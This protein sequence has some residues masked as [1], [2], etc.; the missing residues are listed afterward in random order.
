MSFGRR[1]LVQF[2]EDP[3]SLL[4][5]AT[6]S[7]LLVP[8]AFRFLFV[9]RLAGFHISLLA[10]TLIFAI[11][12]TAFNLLYGYTGL[13][14]FGHA[15]FVAVA[16]YTVATVFTGAAA[17]LAFLGGVAPLATWLLAVVLGV[18]VAGLTAVLIGYLAVQLEEI[19]FA[20]ITLSFSM[21]I[22]ALANQDVPGR[23][24]AEFGIG[25]GTFTNQSDGLTFVPGDVSLFGIEFQLV[26]LTNPV[27]FYVLT[28]F[29]FVGGIYGLWRIVNSPF[30]MTCKAI[31]ENP[32][33]AR[34]IGVDVTYHRWM[35]FI[36]SGLFSGL[37]GAMLVTLQG[38]VNPQAHAYWTASAAPVVMTVIGGPLSFIGPVVG[39][40]TFEYLRW[41]ISQNTLLEQYRQ[42]SFGVLLVVVV[43]FFENGVAGGMS[44]SA[45]RFRAWLEEARARYRADGVRGVAGLVVETVVGWLRA[46]GAAVVAW[47]RT[48]VA[49]VVAL[50]RWVLGLVV[51]L[52]RAV[53]RRLPV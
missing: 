17:Q 39:A 14:S 22:Y 34:A 44:W 28:V 51:G 1:T 15:M 36:I 37:A 38:N 50:I 31:R 16:G 46:A 35:T 5:A 6:L 27:A 19:Y 43:L 3:R 18:C 42:F 8:V 10:E 20:L 49:N 33:R 11:W 29:V 25:D 53:R 21:A 2:E 41:L 13:L 47:V 24:L 4:V 52:F 45:R 48:A 7:L 26:D 30:G 40:F 9:E 12:A 23:L 32:G